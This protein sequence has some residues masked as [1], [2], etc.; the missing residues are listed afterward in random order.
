MENEIKRNMEHYI[1]TTVPS[2]TSVHDLYKLPINYYLR[3]PMRVTSMPKVH[4]LLLCATCNGFGDVVFAHKIKCLLHKIFKGRVEVKIATTNVEAFKTIGEPVR[5]LVQLRTR[6]AKSECRGFRNMTRD[7]AL[8]NYDLYFITPLTQEFTPDFKGMHTLIR[9]S[10]R[11]NTFFFSEYN[12]RMDDNILFQTGIGNGRLGLLFVACETRGSR[13]RLN[14]AH[15]YSVMYMA[16]AE[17]MKGIE[18]CYLGFLELLTS[19]YK[20]DRLDVV[21]PPWLRQ[22]V[23][24]NMDRILRAIHPHYKHVRINDRPKSKTAVPELV[25]RFDILP[26]PYADMTQLYVNSLP[27]AL[28]TGDQSITDFLF[29]RRHKPSVPFYQALPW[30]ISFYTN[31]AKE[32]PQKYFRHKKTSCGDSTAVNY[33]PKTNVFMQQNNFETN[34]SRLLQAV[35]FSAADQS[36]VMVA[37]KDAVL[38]AKNSLRVAKQSILE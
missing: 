28:L 20:Y 6:A 24:E 34:A 36:A 18:H 30:K 22:D 19:T 1:Q 38:R 4:I 8:E 31:L 21:A 3:H 16:D 9:S 23:T 15:P 12:S 33:M 13:R 32:L 35:V 25:F 17:S 2:L 5:N 14:L 27:H 29:V 26:L 7:P 37:Y 10:N 11:F